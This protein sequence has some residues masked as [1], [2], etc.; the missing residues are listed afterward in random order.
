MHSLQLQYLQKS[1]KGK[2]YLLLITIVFFSQLY[3]ENN[4][5]GSGLFMP[6]NTFIWLAVTWFIA[7]SILRLYFETKIIIPRPAYTILLLAGLVGP[8]LAGVIA[9]ITMPV[10]WWFRF[11]FIAGGFA[12]LFGLFQAELSKKQIDFILIAIITLGV[13]N[14]LLSFSQIH[15]AESLTYLLVS[16]HPLFPTGFFQQVNTNASF[17]STTVLICFYL[18]SR[19]VFRNQVNKL[20]LLLTLLNTVASTYVVFYSSSR[21]GTL[22]LIIGLGLIFVS[23]WRM[24]IKTKVLSISLIFALAIGVGAAVSSDSSVRLAAKANSTFEHA[25]ARIGIYTTSIELIKKEPIWGYGIG[26]FEREFVE[27]AGKYIQ[28]NP[29]SGLADIPSLNHPH[30][31][32]LFWFIEGGVIAVLGI[33]AFCFAVMS[34]LIRLGIQRGGAYAALLFPIVLHTQVELPFYLSSNH[35]FLFLFLCFMVLSHKTT[36]ISFQSSLAFKKVLVVTAALIFCM[37]SLFLVNTLKA[38]RGI[39]QYWQQ[40]NGDLGLLVDASQNLYFSRYAERNIMAI[41]GVT[42]IAEGKSEQVKFFINWAESYLVLYPDYVIRDI[43]IKSYHYLGNREKA[44]KNMSEALFFYPKN[45]VLLE[46]D[47]KLSCKLKK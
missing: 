47:S 6:Y 23:R 10:E 4:V 46:L 1:N 15:F 12:F 19:P 41:N 30:N 26:S 20:L 27:A 17:L 22:S 14:S 7:F 43:L 24:L 42:S 13:V 38:N 29:D 11:L 21:V 44:C 37:G 8:L 32:F 2:L 36:K 5:G 33:L 16:T 28:N 3:L 45:K 9:G 18:A 31:E 25:S 35:W 34:A 39:T 40:M